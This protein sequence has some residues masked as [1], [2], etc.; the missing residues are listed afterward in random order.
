MADPT[1]PPP[2]GNV[3][4]QTQLLT[5][6]WLEL[7]VATIVLALRLLC[8]LKVVHGMGWDDYT[9]LLTWVSR[10]HRSPLS[11]ATLTRDRYSRW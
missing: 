2:D 3:S 5:I 8:R 9:M 4:H 1:V 6:I 11:R 7:T 10:S